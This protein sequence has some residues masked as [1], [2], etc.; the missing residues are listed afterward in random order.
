[1]FIHRR[2]VFAISGGFCFALTAAATGQPPLQAR[3]VLW[4]VKKGN[5]KAYILGFSDAPD[6]SWLTPAIEK[7]FQESTEVWFETPQ[8]DPSAP[9]PLPPPKADSAVQPAGFSEKS[10]FDVLKPDLSARVLAAAQKYEVPRDRLE[11]VLPWR[12]YF[13]LNR[14]YFTKKKDAVNIDNYADVT[15]SKMAFAAKK[16]VHSE[17]A[18]GGDAMSHFINMPD[19]EAAERLEFL[20]DFLDDDEAGRDT[21]RYDWISGHN[22]NR[23]IDRMRTKW[24]LLYQDEQVSRNVGWAKRIGGFLAQ[25]GTTFVVIGLQ[26]T[27]GPDSLPNKL[28]A[29][30][31]KPETV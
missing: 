24:P 3:P 27:L 19:A 16:P 8:P 18:T 22:N 25:G 15:L 4:R 12:A 17:F 1:M 9:P 21:D 20:L 29:I 10:L 23:A 2:K 28:R 26:H 13:I 7:A 31:L 14:G 5:A 6:H 30:G 11:H